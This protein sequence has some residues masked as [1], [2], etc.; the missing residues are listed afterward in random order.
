MRREN[1]HEVVLT[2]EANRA[3]CRHLLQHYAKGYLQEDLCFGLW[4]PSRGAPGSEC[5]SRVVVVVHHRQVARVR[6]VPTAALPAQVAF[7]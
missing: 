7:E 4:T 3:A 6:Q 5:R 1:W 2:D